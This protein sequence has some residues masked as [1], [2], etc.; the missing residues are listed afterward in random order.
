MGFRYVFFTL[1]SILSILSSCGQSDGTTTSWRSDYRNLSVSFTN[2]WRKLPS[3]D[4]K[5]QTLI[6]VIDYSDGKS[7]IIKITDDTPQE[8]LTDNQYYE[9]AKKIMLAPNQKNK[10]LSESDTIF[11]GTTVHKIVFL[12]YTDKW[13]LMKQQTLIE[14]DGKEFFSIQILYPVEEEEYDKPVPGSILQLDKSILINGK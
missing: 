1:I 14:R 4:T 9:G 2:P 5:E 12:M 11:H 10:V 3:L 6:G 13:G 7:Y 8:K